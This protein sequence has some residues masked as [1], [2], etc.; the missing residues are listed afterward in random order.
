MRAF[1]SLGER[2]VFGP[3]F[4]LPMGGPGTV[5]IP[6]QTVDKADIYRGFG[7]FVQHFNSVWEG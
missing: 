3:G 4:G 6:G 2:S 7:M 1:L 5:P